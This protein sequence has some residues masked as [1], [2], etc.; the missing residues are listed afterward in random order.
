MA[1]TSGA[2]PMHRIRLIGELHTFLI[3]GGTDHCGTQ[4]A[5]PITNLFMSSALQTFLNPILPV[6]AILGFGMVLARRGVFDAAAAGILNRF[7]FFIGAPALLFS[8]LNK[9]LI[10]EFEWRVLLLY[11]A[12]EMTIYALGAVL[13]RVVFK[14]EWRESLLLGMTGCFVN[15][16]FFV[17][18]MARVLYGEVASAPI[19]AIIT[20]DSV[21]IFTLTIVGLELSAP[22]VHSGRKVITLLLKHP[23]LQAITAGVALNLLGIPLHEGINTFASFVGAAASPIALFA[24]GIILASSAGADPGLDKAALAVTGLKVVA[25]PLLAWVLFSSVA[26]GGATPANPAWISSALLVAAGPC[27]AMP[28]VLALQYRIPVAS[29]A[30]AIAY[31]TLISL[32]TLTW[33][34]S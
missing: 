13:A 21:L 25:H 8:L 31:S 4:C 19:A 27:G 33:I 18:P 11:F 32:I 9:A 1:V 2:T 34:A 23:L 26:W 17:L 7:V 14:R 6:F 24:L 20:V 16:V 3:F 12:S 5:S 22:G 15:H 10:A 29:M 30:R 28:F